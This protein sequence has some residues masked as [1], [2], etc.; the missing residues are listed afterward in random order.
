MSK[1]PGKSVPVKLVYRAEP[2]PKRPVG[3]VKLVYRAEPMPK[4]PER[5]V[6]EY[7]L[8]YPEPE[9]GLDSRRRKSAQIR[10]N[11][12]LKRLRKEAAPLSKGRNRGT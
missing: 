5:I 12:E 9:K 3:P 2:M 6:G 7:K 11:T 8:V 4:R 10:L 1:R